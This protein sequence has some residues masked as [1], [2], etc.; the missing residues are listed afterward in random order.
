MELTNSEK[1]DMIDVYFTYHKNNLMAA[2]M[3]REV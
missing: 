2:N 1:I 3:Y